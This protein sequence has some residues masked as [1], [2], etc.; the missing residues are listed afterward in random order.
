ML[1]ARQAEDALVETDAAARCAALIERVAATP[2]GPNPQA[3][4]AMLADCAVL[5]RTAPNP[6]AV[7]K[8]RDARHW[9]RLAYGYEL[10]AYPAADLRRLMR[11]ALEEFRHAAA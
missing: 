11:A 7:C 9:L 6:S 4:S 2:I 5:E 10:H 3:L 8:L 1:D